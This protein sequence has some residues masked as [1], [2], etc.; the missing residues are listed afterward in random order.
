MLYKK[1]IDW[2]D[3]E[4]PTKINCAQELI[5]Y[6]TIVFDCSY[7]REKK[8]KPPTRNSYQLLWILLDIG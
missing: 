8:K 6:A 3:A 1:E 7:G 4:K 5:T 2:N